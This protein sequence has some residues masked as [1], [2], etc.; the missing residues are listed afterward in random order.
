MADAIQII[1]GILILIAVYLLTQWG[2]AIRI[3]RACR[4]V[5]KDLE[6]KQ[7]FDVQSAVALPYAK[8]EFF[9]MGLKDFRPKAVESLAAA[10]ILGF[11]ADGK[12]YL[13]K[14]DLPV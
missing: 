13:L 7:A 14:R 5:V 4:W 10:G 12:W 8:K 3:R 6:M 11:T 1:L 2:V 9:K